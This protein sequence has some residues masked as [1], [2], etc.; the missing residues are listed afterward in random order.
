M[1]MTEPRNDP[2]RRAQPQIRLVESIEISRERNAANLLSP[3]HSKALELPSG[4][5]L[6][7]RR[8]GSEQLKP[9]I[10]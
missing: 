5:G 4:D 8:R 9:R 7:P 10:G 1:K 3:S 6:E 2:A